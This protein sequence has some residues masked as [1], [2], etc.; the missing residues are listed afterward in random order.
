MDGTDIDALLAAAERSP[1]D[2]RA[3]ILLAVALLRAGRLDEAERQVAAAVRLAPGDG[4]LASAMAELLRDRPADALAAL[5]TASAALDVA[6]AGRAPSPAGPTLDDVAGM[7]EAK[8]EFRLRI[9]AP[10]THPELHAAYG[11]SVGGG[12]L[13]YGP[14]GCGKTLL[15]RAAAGEAGA[16]FLA[17][18]IEEILDM[19]LGA[20]ERNLHDVFVEAR[21]QAPC[22]LFFDEVDALGARR[23]DLRASGGRSVVNQFLAE[24]D[25]VQGAN[26]GVLVLAASNAPWHLDAA[27]R[28]PGR[29]DRVLFRAAAGPG[30]ADAHPGARPRPPAVGGHG[31]RGAG[32][33]DGRSVGRR[34][35]GDRGPRGAVALRRRPG[36]RDRRADHRRRPPGR[37]VG[38]PLQHRRVVRA[39]PQLGPVRQRRRRVG[40]RDAPP[41]RDAVT[42]DPADR[43][44]FHL[45]RGDAGRALEEARR[46]LAEDP[47]EPEAIELEA[48]ALSEM[49][50]HTEA[51]AAARRGVAAWPGWAWPLVTLAGVL[52]QAE[53]WDDAVAVADEALALDPGEPPAW[54]EKA[55][56]ELGRDRPAAALAA[57][58]AGLALDPEVDELTLLRGYAL[59]TL[60]RRKEATAA[61]EEVLGR[62]PDDARAHAALARSDFMGMRFGRAGDGVRSS[63]RLDPEDPESRALL[64]ETARARTPAGRVLY[65][66]LLFLSRFPTWFGWVLVIGLFVL[67]RVLISEWGRSVVPTFILAPFVVLYVVFCLITWFGPRIIDGYLA[68]DPANARLLDEA[69]DDD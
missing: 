38:R 36:V 32:A 55:A 39:G 66:W 30:G 22:V 61:F 57:A 43:G 56:G 46:A 10:L 14:P 16:A 23:A 26:E 17:V 41:G 2:V 62:N 5:E 6:P 67:F 34:P 35:G 45:G 68:T 44:W 48:R 37:P 24:M 64:L 52:R 13:L 20:S 65:P 47:D 59:L 7:E 4:V 19:W 53:R 29:F 28:R 54:L 49:G 51:E 27:F 50:R 31:H 1:A 58:D 25:G 21:R 69:R 12:V 60:R 3:R 8:R 15:A 40:R 33:R 18:G 11:G 63:L 42:S 9:V